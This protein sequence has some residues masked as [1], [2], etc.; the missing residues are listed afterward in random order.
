MSLK[1]HV[2]NDM[3][4]ARNHGKIAQIIYPCVAKA[5]TFFRSD[6]GSCGA[7]QRR[8]QR[9]QLTN[10]RKGHMTSCSRTKKPANRKVMNL[11]AT[12]AS[13]HAH[14][15]VGMAFR[16]VLQCRDGKGLKHAH[17]HAHTSA[18]TTYTYIHSHRDMMYT[19]MQTHTL[20]CSVLAIDNILIRP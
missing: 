10:K 20:G 16:N 7:I 9:Q 17:M 4:S 12:A 8:A 19:C 13:N 15:R 1:I 2:R 5:N 18:K 14:R 3:S 6:K 11:R